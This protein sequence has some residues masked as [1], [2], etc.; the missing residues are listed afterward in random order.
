MSRHQSIGPSRRR[1]GPCLKPNMHKTLALI[2][3]VCKQLRIYTEEWLLLSKLYI[4]SFTVYTTIDKQAI[5]TLASYEFG[6]P[7][8]LHI[9][10]TKIKKWQRIILQ[11][12]KPEIS[13][14]S[15]L[16]LVEC[17]N[18]LALRAPACA[19]QLSLDLSGLVH[20]TP[21]LPGL[22][23]TLNLSMK[24]STSCH[25]TQDTGTCA[26]RWLSGLLQYSQSNFN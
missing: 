22:K 8:S 21:P 16:Q 5:I 20:F 6:Y 3:A 2:C 10:K 24:L 23:T 25:I 4:N 1:E 11:E 7:A 26:K 12:V 13:G 14:K 9:L 19:L 15:Q 17:I 18:A